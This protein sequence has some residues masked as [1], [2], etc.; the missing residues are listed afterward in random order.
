MIRH[1][2]RTENVDR[3]DQ[4]LGP[5]FSFTQYSLS[6]SLRNDQKSS[7]LHMFVYMCTQLYTKPR[8]RHWEL[9][10]K[11]H[12]I[13]PL[14]SDFWLVWLW[15]WLDWDIRRWRNCRYVYRKAGTRWDLHADRD[16]NSNWK[17]QW[18]YYTQNG[19]GAS[20]S[21]RVVPGYIYPGGRSCG[22]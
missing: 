10:Y 3:L 22:W 9:S 19:E 8:S 16:T 14:C 13:R 5:L 18:I 21:R 4:I 12:R 15:D 11:E 1:I 20:L 2:H 17:A 6:Q 7:F